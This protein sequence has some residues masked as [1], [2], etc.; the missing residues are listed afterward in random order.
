MGRKVREAEA[1]H[2]SRED[3]TRA[4]WD[5]ANLLEA[6]PAR[7]GYR[8]RWVGTSILGDDIPQQVARRMRQGWVPRPADTVSDSFHAPTIGHGQFEGCIGVEGM[9]LCE[10]PEERAL[11]REEHFQ[12]LTDN[13][14]EFVDRALKDG[15]KSGHARV[16]KTRDAGFNR[17]QKV[18]ED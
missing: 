2:P 6:P 18:A 11:A 5:D 3:E 9:V 14:T 16:T 10:L 13:Q 7:E 8:Q 4:P 12:G 17:G 15:V 1:V